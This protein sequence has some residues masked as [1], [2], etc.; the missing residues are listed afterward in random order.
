MESNDSCFIKNKSAMQGRESGK[1]YI[2]ILIHFRICFN[3]LG[4]E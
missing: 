3:F 2:D 1:K 4:T